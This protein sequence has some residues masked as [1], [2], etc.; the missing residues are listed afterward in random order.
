MLMLFGNS[1]QRKTHEAE[2]R[3]NYL[4]KNQNCHY[5]QVIY[6]KEI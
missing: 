6:V 2:K 1:K 5:L 3:Y 4:E